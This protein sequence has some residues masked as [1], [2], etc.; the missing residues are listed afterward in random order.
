MIRISALEGKLS[1]LEKKIETIA[2]MVIQMSENQEKNNKVFSKA[3]DALITAHK[4]IMKRF[5]NEE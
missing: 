1:A 4:I 2:G 3:I 5:N